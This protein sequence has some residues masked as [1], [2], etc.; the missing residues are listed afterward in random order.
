MYIKFFWEVGKMITE[1]T[2]NLVGRYIQSNTTILFDSNPRLI[3]GNDLTLFFKSNDTKFSAVV[4]SV[5]GNNA[6]ID[7]NNVQ[8]TGEIVD[9]KTRWYGSGITG[10]QAV[11]SLMNSTT[12]S[13]LLQAISVGG[14]TNTL[15]V[16]ASTDLNG[17]WINL[18]TMVPS[19]ANSNTAFLHITQPWPYARLNI[20]SIAASNSIKV[21][22]AN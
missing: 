11:F 6:V 9:V 12:P 22:K 18:G 7:F 8:Y 21:N 17:G 20:G 13:T 15:S 19:L 1:I 10:A 14:G 4:S 2:R 3:A 5:T 16:E